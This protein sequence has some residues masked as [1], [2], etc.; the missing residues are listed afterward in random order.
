MLQIM[1]AVS[2]SPLQISCHIADRP[3]CARGQPGLDSLVDEIRREGSEATAITANVIDFNQVKAVADRAVE[4]YGRLDTW[5]HS[6]AVS[7]YATF[8]NT[9][10]E[11]FKHI[12]ETNL[13]GQAYGAMA[14]LPHLKREGRGALIHISSAEAPRCAAVSER[15]CGLEAW[16]KRFSRRFAYRVIAR[17]CEHQR[18]GSDAFEHQYTVFRES[19]HS[20][21]GK[22]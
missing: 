6:A 8:E 13:T 14:A 11:E 9:A 10:P 18:H 7:L 2:G 3:P 16:H 17:G 5:V 22:A 20:A 1:R 15:L 12:I 4:R 19:P 21:Y